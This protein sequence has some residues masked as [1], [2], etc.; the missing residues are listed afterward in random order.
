M[1]L[2]IRMIV[3]LVEVIRMANDEQREYGRRRMWS[4]VKKRS[5]AGRGADGRRKKLGRNCDDVTV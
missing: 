4:E 5:G 2:E 1:K 3:M